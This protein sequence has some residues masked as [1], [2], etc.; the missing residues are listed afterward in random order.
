M[1]VDAS[2]SKYHEA[3][4]LRSEFNRQELRHCRLILRRL[5]FLEAQ[6]EASGGIGSESSSGG[7][8][9]AEW[10]LAALEWML[11]ELGYLDETNL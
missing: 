8:A 3:P 6:I 9:F 7:G 10:E 11:I 2:K 1:K 5:R 4:G